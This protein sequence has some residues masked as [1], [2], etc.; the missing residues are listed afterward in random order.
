MNSWEVVAIL[1]HASDHI[2]DSCNAL[3]D[4]WSDSYQQATET[5]RKLANK[6]RA[7]AQKEAR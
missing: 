3:N 5:L 1:D 2:M 6:A 7:K 4:S